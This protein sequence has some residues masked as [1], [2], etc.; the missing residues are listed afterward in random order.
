MN[1]VAQALKKL[2]IL[3]DRK[4]END[5]IIVFTEEIAK[6][7]Y[8]LDITLSGIERLFK[9]SLDYI[10]LDR[11]LESISKSFMESQ[12]QIEAQKI[13]EKTY[14]QAEKEAEK[15]LFEKIAGLKKVHGAKNWYK[16]M[17]KKAD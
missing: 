1:L 6:Q 10:A 3:H 12:A 7:G 13:I 15:R 4:C 2:F 17:P 5:K 11:I 16:F 9:I 14:T 8:Q